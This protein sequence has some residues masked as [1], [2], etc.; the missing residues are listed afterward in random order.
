MSPSRTIV[1]SAIAFALA[2]AASACG[3]D[4]A[5]SIVRSEAGPDPSDAQVESD[6]SVDADATADGGADATADA[7]DGALADAPADAIVGDAGCP[8]NSVFCESSGTCTTDKSCVSCAGSS[9]CAASDRCVLNC[10][11]S[12]GAA[13][14]N[15]GCFWCLIAT[16]TVTRSNCEP[17]AAASC[18]DNGTLKPVGLD[19]CPCADPSPAACPGP[20]LVCAGIGGGAHGC[21]PCG[22]MGTDNKVCKANGSCAGAAFTCAL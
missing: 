8:P 18:L 12:C 1:R 4:L 17:V 21:R 15:V 5:G 9:Y 6:G 16:S 2:S 3:L 19:Y 22:G 13:A 20:A 7:L 14:S 11:T 10:V